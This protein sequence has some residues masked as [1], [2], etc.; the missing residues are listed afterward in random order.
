ME[1][2]IL[3]IFKSGCEG[4]IIVGNTRHSSELEIL[5]SSFLL[6]PTLL[7]IANWQLPL[8]SN[9]MKLSDFEGIWR[10]FAHIF[11]K[12]AAFSY[13]IECNSRR[14]KRSN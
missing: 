14:I 3:E 12:F 4:F 5:K 9:L 10:A 7:T 1:S 8:M 2:W 11:E 6:T 13:E